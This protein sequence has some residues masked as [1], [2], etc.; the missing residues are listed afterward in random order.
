MK[1][2]VQLNN[3]DFKEAKYDNKTKFPID[4]N[5]GKRDLIEKNAHNKLIQ[6]DFQKVHDFCIRKKSRPF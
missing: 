1:L 3:T 4:F 5:V 2:N 6:R